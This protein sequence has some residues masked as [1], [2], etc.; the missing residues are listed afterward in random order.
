[1]MAGWASISSSGAWIYYPARR[2]NCGWRS[3]CQ[4]QTG[5]EQTQFLHHGL[6]LDETG[7]KLSKSTQTGHQR[8]ILAEAVAPQV[9][10]RAVAQL[11]GLA[12]EAGESLEALLAALT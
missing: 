1:M 6:V 12:P 8:G 5:F 7:Q 10:Y 11:L 2:P 3:T 4:G 9:V